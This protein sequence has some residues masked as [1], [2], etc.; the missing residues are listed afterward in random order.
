[1]GSPAVTL[2]QAGMMRLNKDAA[3]ILKAMKATHVLILW[4]QDNS[5]VAISPTPGSDDRAYTLHY[6]P[7]GSGVAFAAKA[8]L[9]HIGWKAQKAVPLRLTVQKGMLQADLPAEYINASGEPTS[10]K[11]GKKSMP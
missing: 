7:K 6:H 8:F 1:M 11:K 3:D 2:T 9:K 5:K 4:D 10:K